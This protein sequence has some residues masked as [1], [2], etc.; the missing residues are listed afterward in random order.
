MG[1]DYNDI[2]FNDQRPP[3]LPTN[4]KL[5]SSLPVYLKY[6]MEIALILDA[7]NL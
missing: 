7:G 2:I 6:G 4:L 1:S 5:K 3:G